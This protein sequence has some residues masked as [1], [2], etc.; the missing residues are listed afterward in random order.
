MPVIP[1]THELGPENASLR[2]ETRRGGAAAK[3][4]HDLVIEVSSWEGMLQVGEDPGQNSLTLSADSGSMEV[5]EGTGGIK[6]LTDEDKV[7]IKKTLEAE[8]LQPGQVEFKST[9]VTPMD[10]G[11]RLKVSGELSMNGNVHPLDFE[12][13]FGPDGAVSGRA[14]VKQSDWGIELYSGLFGTLRVKDEV[15]VVGEAS[16]S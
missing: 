12:L 5:V 1:G 15:E 14:T 3:A 13:E 6:A 11:E 10:D 2:I 8:V 9:A 16:L 4:G 7:E